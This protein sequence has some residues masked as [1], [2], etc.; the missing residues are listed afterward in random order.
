[1]LIAMKK[2]QLS[3]DKKFFYVTF[4]E[5]FSGLFYINITWH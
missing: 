2:S 4:V 3:I 5:G 1:M